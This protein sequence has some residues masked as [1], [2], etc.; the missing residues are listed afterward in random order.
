MWQPQCG[1][2]NIKECFEIPSFL[3]PGSSANPPVK[4]ALEAGLGPHNSWPLKM[5]F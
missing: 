1:L 5:T 3:N 4:V 2:K